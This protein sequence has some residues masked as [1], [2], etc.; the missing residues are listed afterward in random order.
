LTLLCSL[1]CVTIT[2]VINL[3]KPTILK[4]TT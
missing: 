4:I 1:P 2:I 3:L